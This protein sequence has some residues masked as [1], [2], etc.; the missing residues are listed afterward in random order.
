MASRVIQGYFVG[1][2]AP[3]FLSKTAAVHPH[4]AAIQAQAARGSAAARPPGPPPPAYAGPSSFGANRMVQPRPAPGRPPALHDGPASPA[5]SVAQRFGGGDSFEIDPAHVGLAR[6]GGRP[7]PQAVRAKMEAAFGADFSAVRVHIGPQAARIGAIGFTTGNDLYFAPG[8]FQPESVKGQ[9][10]IGHELAHVIQQRQG[11]V[12]APGSGVA[13]VQD[14]A[15]EAEADRL[16]MRAAAH[17]APVR[18]STQRTGARHIQ[19]ASEAQSIF[20]NPEIVW[21]TDAEWADEAARL[22]AA[23]SIFQDTGAAWVDRSQFSW[24]TT[25][26]ARGP[27]NLT[28]M[29]IQDITRTFG[30]GRDPDGRT[31]RVRQQQFFECFPTAANGTSGA[32]QFASDLGQAPHDDDGWC[33][34]L[35]EGKLYFLSAQSPDFETIRNGFRERHPAVPN[36]ID[37]LAC[38][39]LD[40][41]KIG[42]QLAYRDLYFEYNRRSRAK[43]IMIMNSTEGVVRP[44]EL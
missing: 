41:T 2:R 42:P 20:S 13:V 32:D 18:I 43:R 9:Q 26:S 5:L 19:R 24:L 38:P 30:T 6:G 23:V 12:R 15:L 34:T 33:Y 10:L 40:R 37:M 3:A 35:L 36:E 29:I 27:G 7:L 44:Q 28:G 16:G 4:A 17:R 22:P 1:G 14:R 31:N 39:D 25:F 21:K 8:Q 11:R